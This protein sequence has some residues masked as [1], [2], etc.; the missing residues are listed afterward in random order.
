MRNRSPRN[1]PPKRRKRVP[2]VQGL[3]LESLGL[4]ALLSAVAGLGRS[5]WSTSRSGLA[6]QPVAAPATGD[7]AFATPFPRWI[8]PRM[9]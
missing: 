8:I 4:L 3:L 9:D 1:R 5:Y 2:V 7:S 6:L